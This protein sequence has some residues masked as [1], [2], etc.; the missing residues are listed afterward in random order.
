MKKKNTESSKARLLAYSQIFT[1]EANETGD[2]E[3][4]KAATECENFVREHC[5]KQ[6]KT[7]ARGWFG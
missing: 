1:R 7:K 5:S 6:E 3:L 2:E 4:I